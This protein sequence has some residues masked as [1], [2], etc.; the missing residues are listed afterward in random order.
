MG[1]VR[2]ELK[3]RKPTRGMCPTCAIAAASRMDSKAPVNAPTYSRRFIIVPKSS[4]DAQGL[5]DPFEEQLDL[6]AALVEGGDRQRRSVVLLVRNT[7][8]L[9]D[10]GSLKRMRRR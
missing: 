6:P 1:S 9:P 3:S 10:S 8:V 4:L 5:L 2:G 7:S